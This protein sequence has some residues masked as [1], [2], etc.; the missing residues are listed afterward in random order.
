M[1]QELIVSVQEGQLRG[2]ICYDFTGG[3]YFSFQGIPYAKPALGPLRFK[4][5]T[6]YGNF[7]E[8]NQNNYSSKAPQPPEPWRDIKDATTEGNVCYHL[9]GKTKYIGAEDCL[10]LNVY[11][12]TVS[13]KVSLEE[14]H[15]TLSDEF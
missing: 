8:Y 7:I 14:F 12:P 4:V 10:F 15:F 2:K 9:S 6:H 5:C 13:Y 11:T 1:T 3:Q